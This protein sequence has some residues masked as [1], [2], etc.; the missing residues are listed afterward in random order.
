MTVKYL[1]ASPG[2]SGSLYVARAISRSTGLRIISDAE[3]YKTITSPVVYHTHHATLQ[4][5]DSEDLTVVCCTRSNL[6][7]TTISAIIGEI[8]NE[9]GNYTGNQKPFNISRDTVE[10]KYVWNRWWQHQFDALNTYKNKI[11]LEFEEFTKNPNLIFDTLGIPVADVPVIKSPYTEQHI[12]NIE[13]V[14]QWIS[15]FE[16]D[17]MLEDFALNTF[18]WHNGKVDD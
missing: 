17:P 4:L 15:E 7:A 5:E 13:E 6:Y 8:S 9:W 12:I 14:K 1:V 2:R 16:N 18:Q 10:Q 11:Y 3:N